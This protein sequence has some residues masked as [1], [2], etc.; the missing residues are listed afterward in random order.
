MG[1]RLWFAGPRLPF[2]LR[3]GISV[4]L[5]DLTRRRPAPAPVSGGIA[6]SYV[7]VVASQA[8]TVKI[9]YSTNPQMRMAAL[10]TASAA[11]LRLAHVMATDIDGRMLEAEAHR[12]L[13]RHRLSGE[14][15]DVSAEV[16]IEAVETAAKGLGLPVVSTD[17]ERLAEAVAGRGGKS[18]GG[19]A[20]HPLRLF[21]YLVFIMLGVMMS[22]TIFLWYLTADDKNLN[23]VII[24]M[25]MLILAGPFFLIAWLIKRS[26]RNKTGSQLPV[27]I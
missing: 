1:I 20:T 11:P 10:Q 5:S 18:G 22:G 23:L 2:G 3:A 19:L 27:I 9:G 12:L 16:A 14:W 7:Y 26:W 4:P 15:F 13:D 8:G 17:S 25:M 6:L 21:F 24:A